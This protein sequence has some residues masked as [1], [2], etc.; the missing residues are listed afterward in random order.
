MPI[1]LGSGRIAGIGA[2]A[3]RPPLPM[4]LEGST[5]RWIAADRVPTDFPAAQLVT[6]TSVTYTASD[7]VR[8]HAQLFLPPGDRAARRPAIVYVHGGPPRQ[9]LLGWHYGDYYANAY[10]MNQYLANRGFVVLSINYRLGIGYGYEFHRPPNAGA[11]GA[12]EPSDTGDEDDGAPDASDGDYERVSEEAHDPAPETPDETV[13]E[14]EDFPGDRPAG[15]PE[16][17]TKAAKPDAEPRPL[18]SKPIAETAEAIRAAASVIKAVEMFDAFTQ[19]DAGQTCTDDEFRFV[20][21]ARDER[22]KKGD[23]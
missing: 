17:R 4:V 20:E 19:S 21:A 14:A 13:I 9:M 12:S 10:A 18:V 6:P 22:V 7:G 23:A 8:V 16:P 1:M 2:T 11:Q 3:Q 5:P 15:T